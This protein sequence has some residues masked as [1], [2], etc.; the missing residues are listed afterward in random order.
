MA[1]APRPVTPVVD[2]SS[3][4]TQTLIDAGVLPEEPVPSADPPPPVDDGGDP[5]PADGAA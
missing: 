2:D 3:A 4:D 1:L 5:Q